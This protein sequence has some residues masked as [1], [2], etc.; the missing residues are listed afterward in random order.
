MVNE[1]RDLERIAPLDLDTHQADRFF[2]KLI[3][4]AGKVDQIAG[5]AHRPVRAIGII[6]PKPG[7]LC[8]PRFD[9]L[10]RQR[11]DLPLPL[12][13]REH[14]HALELQLLGNE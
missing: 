9:L 10:I 2:P 7:K 8:C 1:Q 5:V 13:L 14:L 11:L 3:I 12:V 6:P 4:R